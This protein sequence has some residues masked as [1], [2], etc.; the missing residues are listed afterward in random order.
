MPVIS[1]SLAKVM[2]SS[3]FKKIYR[4]IKLKK[5]NLEE[6]ITLRAQIDCKTVGFFLKISKEIGKA[7]RSLF[8]ASF[9]T[10]C[11]TARA[12]LNTQKYGLFCSLGP[13]LH[14]YCAPLILT[15]HHPV[16]STGCAP[17]CRVG[18]RLFKPRLDQ[19]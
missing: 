15:N 2:V 12:Y 1:I 6:V 7:W 10:F 14:V 9:Q 13:K 17:V 5:N 3:T 11:S 18:G 16:N 8:S 4:K 19:H